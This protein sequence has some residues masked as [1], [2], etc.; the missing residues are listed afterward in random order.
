MVLCSVY[1]YKWQSFYSP[2]NLYCLLLIVLERSLLYHLFGKKYDNPKLTLY[3][4]QPSIELVQYKLFDPIFLAK[5]RRITHIAVSHHVTLEQWF[6]SFFGQDPFL[7]LKII[8]NF[9]ELLFI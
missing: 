8:K 5:I 9:K 3:P 1:F 2:L 7:L 6:S 4:K